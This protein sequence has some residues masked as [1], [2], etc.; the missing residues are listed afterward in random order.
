MWIK[1]VGSLTYRSSCHLI[2]QITKS[3]EEFL[4]AEIESNRLIFDQIET[5]KVCLGDVLPL[6]L[7]QVF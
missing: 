4:G 6:R 7:A 3:L 2:F 1:I 5:M